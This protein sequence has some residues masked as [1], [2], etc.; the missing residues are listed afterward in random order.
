[1]APGGLVASWVTASIGVSTMRLSAISRRR[2]DGCSVETAAFLVVV[3]ALP[4]PS[5]M[6][7]AEISMSVMLRL[8]SSASSTSTSVNGSLTVSR[9]LAAVSRS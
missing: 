9:A 3:I 7:F 6:V 4:V 2:I 1:M 5:R 8:M